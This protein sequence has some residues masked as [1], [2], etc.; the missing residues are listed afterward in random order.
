MYTALFVDMNIVVKISLVYATL[1][2]SSAIF[3]VLNTASVVYHEST[4]IQLIFYSVTKRA[5]SA[6]S[7]V[8]VSAHCANGPRSVKLNLMRLVS[9]PQQ[10]SSIIEALSSRKIGFYFLNLFVI[11]Y[12]RFYEVSARNTVC[13]C[14]Y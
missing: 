4:R 5:Y 11:N 1:L 12:F 14:H 9:V 3:F 7:L 6:S 8:K 13:P 2:S 10:I